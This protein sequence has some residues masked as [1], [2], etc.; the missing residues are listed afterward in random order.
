MKKKI[1]K[2]GVVSKPPNEKQIDWYYQELLKVIEKY[3]FVTNDK[4]T[5]KKGDSIYILQDKKCE[6]ERYRGS[7]PI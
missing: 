7:D 5:I 6:R 2:R 3:Y 4:E 1:V